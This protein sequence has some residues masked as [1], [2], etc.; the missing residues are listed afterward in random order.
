ML[1]R[2]GYDISFDVATPTPMVVMLYLHPSRFSDQHQPEALRIE[3]YVPVDL[4]TDCFGNTCARILAPAGTIRFI[5][6]AVIRD[7][8]EPDPIP[9]GPQ[10]PVEELPTDTLQFLLSSRYCEVDLLQDTAWELFGKTEE[11]WPRVKSIIDWVHERI[12]FNYQ[13]ASSTRT[14]MGGYADCKGVC[15][16]FQHLAITLTRCM[17]IPAR[18][19]TGYLGD[20][21][22]PPMPAPMDF[23]AWYE[24]FL[25]GRWWTVDARHNTPRIGRILMARGRDAVDVA[26]TT[27]FGNTKLKNFTVWSDEIK[28]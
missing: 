27:A 4:F 23:S 8:G 24:V 13:D 1:I 11:G 16:D 20:I 12:K 21:G 28:A 9:E 17:N 14:A 25:G 2:V 19:A 6:D 5:N 22:I 26:L 15:R 7:S 3:P 18:Y 10:H